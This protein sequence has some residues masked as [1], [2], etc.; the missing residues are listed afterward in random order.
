MPY[1]LKTDQWGAIQRLR[2][3]KPLLSTH[4]VQIIGLCCMIQLLVLYY[5]TS[6]HLPCNIRRTQQ[7]MVEYD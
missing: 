4:A 1:G 7:K 6:K 5:H 2:I 3:N